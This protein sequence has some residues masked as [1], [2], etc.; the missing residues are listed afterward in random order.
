MKFHIFIGSLIQITAPSRDEYQFVDRKG[1]HSI[2]AM[3]IA[4]PDLR[5]YAFSSRWPG[6]TNDARV[7]GQVLENKLE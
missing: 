4:G 3:G 7:Y 2:N 1:H 6:S 5:F